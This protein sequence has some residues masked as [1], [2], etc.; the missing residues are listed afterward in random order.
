M[1]KILFTL[2]ILL[3]SYS[4]QV[5]A[6]NNE[7]KG[8]PFASYTDNKSPKAEALHYFFILDDTQKDSAYL[9]NISNQL[10]SLIKTGE[11]DYVCVDQSVVEWMFVDQYIKG[12][13]RLTHLLDYYANFSCTT[14]KD[15]KSALSNYH[16][17]ITSLLHTLKAHNQNVQKPVS[18]VGVDFL[19]DLENK[20]NSTWL[21]FPINRRIVSFNKA[22]VTD[23]LMALTDKWWNHKA[24]AANTL[25]MMNNN[26][27]EL[28]S[29][30]GQEYYILW[31]Q[32]FKRYAEKQ[33][34]QTEPSPT[35]RDQQLKE[36]FAYIDR[37][38]PGR[39]I[40]IGHEGFICIISTNKTSLP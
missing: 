12:N 32:F 6:Q 16:E 25:H 23:S 34:A 4:I 21:T 36:D 5:F 17:V 24:V 27:A 30:I 33:S 31:K 11:Y 37:E 15:N 9:Q 7:Y 35:M 8:T 26:K 22:T 29:L 10:D 3:I 1:K 38:L 40:I 19:P 39:K 14:P 18:V 13:P 2:T 28:T 20:H